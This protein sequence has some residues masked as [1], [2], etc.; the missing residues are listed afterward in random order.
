MAAVRAIDDLLATPLLLCSLWRLSTSSNATTGTMKGMRAPRE[1]NKHSRKRRDKD[2]LEHSKQLDADRPSRTHEQD[3]K[4]FSTDFR[5]PYSRVSNAPRES[6]KTKTQL[7]T[8][9][10]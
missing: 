5:L 1:P 10:D 3:T 6:T 7:Q 8:R 2:V 4:Q 9:S